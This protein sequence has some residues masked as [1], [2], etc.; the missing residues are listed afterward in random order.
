MARPEKTVLVLGGTGH[1]GRHIVKS[2]VARGVPT[3]VLTRDA[4]RARRILA[5]A[6]VTVEGNIESRDAVATAM[7]G[8]DSVVVSISAFDR[9]QIGRTEIIERDAVMA[10]LQEA[11]SA[12]VDRVVYVSVFDIREALARRLHI[13]SA[14]AKLDVER[15]LGTSDFNWTILGAPP[16][17]EIFFSMMRGDWMV[18]PGGGPKALPTISPVDL[19]EIAA[20]AALRDDLCGQRIRVA[21]PDLLSFPEAAR[22]LSA[23]YGRRIRFLAVPLILPRSLWYVT[24]PLIRFSSTLR[25]VNSIPGYI[26]LLNAFPQDAADGAP[27]DHKGLR[28]IFDY[29]P[30]TLEMDA[31]LR[32]DRAEDERSVARG[33]RLAAFRNNAENRSEC[34]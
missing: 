16:S 13:D 9:K 20:Q 8:V 5:G 31:R 32:A 22:R 25:F 6:V 15:H 17:S 4:I 29:S 11:R 30:I 23:V 10:A 1:Y 18:V 24:R 33:G 27:A 21:G 2:L 3:R 12:G 19:G 7:R 14:R 34:T 26:E 28:R